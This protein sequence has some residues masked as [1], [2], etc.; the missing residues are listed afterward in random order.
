MPETPGTTLVTGATGAIGGALVGLLLD[1]GHPIKVMARRAEQVEALRDRGIDAARGDFADSTS[2][3]TAMEGC[4]Q[5]F[6]L[7]PSTPATYGTAEDV[8]SRAGEAGIRHIVKISSA[9]ANPDS[10]VPWAADHG[11]S[12]AFL[13]DSGIA[14]TRLQPAAFM[15]NLLE[16]TAVIRRG[17][18]PGTSGH[19]ATTWID[20][21]DIAAAAA[22]VLLNADRQGGPRDAGRSYTLTGTQPLSFPQV[23]ETLTTELHRSVR[24]LHVPGPLM[25]LGLRVGGSPHGEARGLVAQFADIVRHGRDGVRVFSPDLVELIGR[26]ATDLPQFVRAHRAELT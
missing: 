24:Y 2:I 20:D 13:R 21:P 11:R 19:G 9:D 5:L 15:K 26:P 10:P 4:D 23:A 6:L 16:M 8:I 7:P 14:W 22:A 25:Y 12:D 1:A 17:L 18:L 3:A